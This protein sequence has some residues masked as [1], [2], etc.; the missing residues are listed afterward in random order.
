MSLT[1][2]FADAGRWC[3]TFRLGSTSCGYSSSEECM[4]TSLWDRSRPHGAKRAATAFTSIVWT[5]P[6]VCGHTPDEFPSP[7]YCFRSVRSLVLVPDKGLDRVFVFRFDGVNG[8]L[9]PAEP[10][11]V[12]TR[13]GAGPRHLA[14]HPKLP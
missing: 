11:S 13:P 5:L 2:T 14:F 1:S 12:K 8:H 7:R 4:Q 10:D 3:G 6:P 9:S